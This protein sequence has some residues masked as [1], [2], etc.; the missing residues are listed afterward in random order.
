MENKEK[1]LPLVLNIVLKV[2]RQKEH[3]ER[4]S[5]RNQRILQT[6]VYLAHLGEI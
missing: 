3:T 6:P 1:K 2:M 4:L 5:A